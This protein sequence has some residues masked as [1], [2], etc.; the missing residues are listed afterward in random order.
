MGLPFR[1]ILA[2]DILSVLAAAKPPI[3]IQLVSPQTRCWY[4]HTSPRPALH[5]SGPSPRPPRPGACCTSS[6]RHRPPKM[7]CC[8]RSA[9]GQKCCSR[10]TARRAR[11]RPRML[12][13][14]CCGKQG[15]GSGAREVRRETGR[16]RG[17]G[18]QEGG[19]E[20]KRERGGESEGE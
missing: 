11:L 9:R 12:P 18:R 10:N 19:G 2:S 14:V 13:V 3:A 5:N 16:R 1:I 6:R 7:P 20:R 15:E 17:G 4:P 8:R